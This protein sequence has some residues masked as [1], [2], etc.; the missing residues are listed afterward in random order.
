MGQR[1]A[2]SA[3]MLVAVYEFANLAGFVAAHGVWNAHLDES[4]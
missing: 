4:V 1:R 2:A 3:G